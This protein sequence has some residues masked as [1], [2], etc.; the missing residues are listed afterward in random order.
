MKATWKERETDVLIIGTGL[1]GLRAAIEA[2][3]FGQRVLMIDKALIGVNNNTALAGGGFKGALPGILD[4]E[5]EK[6]YDTPDEHFYDTVE[7]GEYLAD[8]S[9]VEIMALEAPG[10]ILELQEFNIPHFEALCSYGMEKPIILADGSTAVDANPARGGQVVTFG[11]VEECE[12]LGVKTMNGCVLL[13]LLEGPD[14]VVGALMYR[15]FNGTYFVCRAA[16]TILA[17]GGAG[18]IYRINY[19][20]NVTT[21]DGYAAAHRVGAELINMEF[22]MFSPHTMMEPGLPMWYILPC[23]A[24]M[25][26]VYRNGRGEAFLDNVLTPTGEITDNFLKRYGELSS[27]IREVI[28]RAIATEIFEGRGDGDAI[29]LDF[30]EVPEELWEA[31]LPSRYNLRCLVRDFDW[32]NKPL[33]ISPGAITHLG[34]VGIDEWGRTNIPGLFCAGEVAAPVHGSR[35]RGGNAFTE[36]LVFGTRAGR[37]AAEQARD[38]K[39]IADRIDL[40]P[41]HARMAEIQSWHRPATPQGDPAKIREQIQLTM[42][43]NAGPLRTGERLEKCLNDLA[44]IRNDHMPHIHANT[45]FEVK[46]AVE[47]ESLLEVSEMVALCAQFRTESRGG[48]FRADIPGIDNENWMCQTSTLKGRLPS[49]RQ[50]DVTRVALPTAD[51]PEQ[52]VSA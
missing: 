7:Y 3:R 20:T 52:L 33:R 12:R 30:R 32:R 8:Q 24:R 49:K 1:A 28:S 36:C 4:T 27:D 35:R 47:V 10:R 39:S 43:E 17:T 50:V 16:T 25:N 29:W 31:D 15:I 21:G 41:V 2:R 18:E 44:R 26:A 6:Q 22:T 19:T 38:N 42:W 48:H 46:A 14:G 13:A 5:I 11:F 37:A 45:P 51:T 40:E 9:L 34:G 23:V